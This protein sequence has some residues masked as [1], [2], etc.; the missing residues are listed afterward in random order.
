MHLFAI[1]RHI[2]VALLGVHS[3]I[4]RLSRD[5]QIKYAA[6]PCKDQDR[7]LWLVVGSE[8]SSRPLYIRLSLDRSKTLEACKYL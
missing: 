6:D 7:G 4:S 2:S 1:V 8:C 5:V 3:L